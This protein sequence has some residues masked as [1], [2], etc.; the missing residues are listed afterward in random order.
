M[1]K[2]KVSLEVDAQNPSGA[3]RLYDKAGMHVGRRRDTCE[4]ELRPVW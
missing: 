3:T 4:K 2:R 1:G